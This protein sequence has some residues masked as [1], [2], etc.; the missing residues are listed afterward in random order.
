[1]QVPTTNRRRN[2]GT[3][4]PPQRHPLGRVCPLRPPVTGQSRDCGRRGGHFGMLHCQP[5]SLC[6]R[7]DQTRRTCRVRCRRTRRGQKWHSQGRELLLR[8]GRIGG[9]PRHAVVLHIFTR[10]P[11]GCVRLSAT[12]PDARMLAPESR[13]PQLVGQGGGCAL[14]RRNLGLPK[15]KSIFELAT[16]TMLAVVHSKFWTG[17]LTRRSASQAHCIEPRQADVGYNLAAWGSG[18]KSQRVPVPV[19]S[20]WGKKAAGKP[21]SPRPPLP[22]LETIKAES[23]SSD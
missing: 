4:G 21:V 5:M 16:R 7:P 19:R 11:T 10:T 15:R 17:I 13:P 3:G 9:W 8:T 2:E 6:Q 1:L 23:F 18:M 14:G 12:V 20:H 22:E